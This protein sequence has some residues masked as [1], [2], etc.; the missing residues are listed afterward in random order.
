[1][2]VASDLPLDCAKVAVDSVVAD[3]VD[4]RCRAVLTLEGKDKP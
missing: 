1:M 2:A 3:N 4:R